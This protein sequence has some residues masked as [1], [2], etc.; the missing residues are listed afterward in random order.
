V[1]RT[2]RHFLAAFPA[3][4]FL[5]GDVVITNDP[6][7][8]TGHLPDVNILMP[9]HDGARLLGFVAVVAHMPD[10][11][12]RILA[13]DSREVFEEGV[14]IPMMYLSRSGER[15]RTLLQL[16]EANVRVPGEVIGDIDGMMS[17][18]HVAQGGLVALAREVE[19]DDFRPVSSELQ[20]RAEVAM[21]RG[22]RA[23]PSAC[24]EGVHR[25]DGLPEDL[26]IALRLDIDPVAG[27]ISL[28]YT[29]TSP[30]VR[31]ALNT[32]Y[33]HAFTYS[34]Y[35][36]KCLLVPHLPFNEGLLRPIRVDI[37][38]LTILNSASPA[39]VGARHLVG[40]M[41]ATLIIRL[42]A[43]ML[44]SA[45]IAECGSPRPFITVTGSRRDGSPFSV[46][47]LVMGG[48]GA[49]ATSDGP[50][51]L[52]FPTNTE[53]VP[54][55]ALESTAPLLV[56]S[57]EFIPDSGGAGRMRGGLAQR[58]VVRFL[59]DDMQLS[60]LAS[61][62]RIPAAGIFGGR[63]GRRAKVLV[64][65]AGGMT[66]QPRGVVSVRPG[67]RLVV[68]SPGGGGYGQPR[69]RPK[70][71]VARDVKAGYVTRAAAVHVYG[72]SDPDSK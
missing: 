54:I 11:G 4:D 26:T 67:D 40:Q 27:E 23:I 70:E 24:C 45:A 49:R 7:L 1:S 56:E 8:G 13:I 30:Q 35:A 39:A 21:R 22:I 19:L 34:C 17:A 29:G 36:L 63:A 51:A 46:P 12:G 71:F 20:S 59:G 42:L 48:F 2:V 14:R 53:A 15:N 57:K 9:V 44:P 65:D 43:P 10:I 58:M 50:S 72:L 66:R 41:V 28:D 69:K 61:R 55:E 6:W 68:E 32:T 18:G 31:S 16:L 62:T 64:E 47:L 33:A 60:S 25:V 5:P 37:P 3:R 38:E 52:P